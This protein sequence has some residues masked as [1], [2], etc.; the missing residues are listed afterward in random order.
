[1]TPLSET[2]I[3]ENLESELQSAH[4]EASAIR[5]LFVA[6]VRS[7]FLRRFVRSELENLAFNPDHVVR[8]NAGQVSFTLINSA[9]FDY[10]IRL[11][12]PFAGRPHTVKW[13]GERQILSVKG[14]SG[15]TMRVLTVPADI[16][17]FEVG[18]PMAKVE[19]MNLEH[20]AF[21]ES[22]SSNYVLDTYEVAA[23]VIFEV[24][25]IHDEKVELHWT[26]DEQLRSIY[27]ESSKMT[28][29]RLRNVLELAGKMGHPVPDGVYDVIFTQ[30][31]AQA[32]LL[33][34]QS[35]LLTDSAAGFRE[36]QKAIE[37]DDPLLSTGAQR[38]F[39]TLMTRAQ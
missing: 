20:G 35:L 13:L 10:T 30:G 1:V 25:T 22:P 7:G 34:V 16:N 33:A 18:V 38:F 6:H 24:L 5:A 8:R 19:L 36:L 31:D 39:D 17:R 27:A 12:P 28:C 26:F 2:G 29:S 21:L 23:P 37:S 9:D 32:K 4:G 11:S 14:A 3:I 15:V